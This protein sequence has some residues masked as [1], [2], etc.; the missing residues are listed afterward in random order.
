M[1]KPTKYFLFSYRY[2]GETEPVNE[3]SSGFPINGFGQCVIVGPKPSV[4]Q[5]ILQV[6][7]KKHDNDEKWKMV[8]PVFWQEITK[9]EYKI[10]MDK[11]A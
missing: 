5:S 4:V 6:R 9:Q 8:I 11:I 2:Y 10:F 7:D 3:N 1:A